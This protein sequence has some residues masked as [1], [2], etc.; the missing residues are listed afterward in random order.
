MGIDDEIARGELPPKKREISL[1]HIDDIDE[2]TWQDLFDREDV[3]ARLMEERDEARAEA[4]AMRLWAEEAAR[5]E[6]AN[7]KDLHDLRNRIYEL[8]KHA[9]GDTGITE[10][11][12]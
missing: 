5:A 9:A 10:T 1:R 2:P 4:H 3:I 11:P 6:N 12:V 7:A 8:A